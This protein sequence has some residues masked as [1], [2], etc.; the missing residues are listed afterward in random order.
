[1]EKNGNKKM[2]EEEILFLHCNECMKSKP[3]NKSP[4][5]Y[6]RISV[7]RTDFGILIYCR[8]HEMEVAHFPYVWTHPAQCQCK[9]CKNE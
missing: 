5:E 6:S 1:M 8:R 7:A 9:G 4:E 2:S 3:Q